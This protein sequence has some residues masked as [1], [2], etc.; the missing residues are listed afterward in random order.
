MSD[1]QQNTVIST[2]NDSESGILATSGNDERLIEE[3]KVENRRLQTESRNSKT[4]IKELKQELQVWRERAE[5]R[6]GF[7][8]DGAFMAAFI[9]KMNQKDF[10]ATPD[11]F[12]R[13]CF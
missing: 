2:E 5:K 4:E 3:L 11:D 7:G 10:H 13:V 6:F 9:E 12:G 8:E 1:A